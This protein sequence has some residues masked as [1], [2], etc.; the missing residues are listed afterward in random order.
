MAELSPALQA[1]AEQRI[2]RVRGVLYALVGIWGLHIVISL[3]LDAQVEGGPPMWLA[4]GVLVGFAAF[5][6]LGAWSLQP[7]SKRGWGT[8]A[9]AAAVNLLHPLLFIPAFYVVW[10][11]FKP[12]V[13]ASCLDWVFAE[14]LKD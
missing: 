13:M 10:Q 12:A 1:E 3:A 6:A 7:G 14:R 8:C 11:L 5:T 9:S 2:A 4:R